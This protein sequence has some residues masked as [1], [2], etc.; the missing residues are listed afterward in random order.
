MQRSSSPPLGGP[1]DPGKTSTRAGL[2]PS[3]LPSGSAAV[4]ALVGARFGQGLG[5][6]WA[7]GARAP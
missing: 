5:S 6:G 2:G 1:G 3:T 7:E 4:L